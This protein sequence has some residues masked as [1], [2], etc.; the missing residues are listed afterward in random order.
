MTI[1]RAWATPLTIGA[2]ALSATTGVLMFFHVEQGLQKE[3]HEWLGWALVIGVAAHLW[4]N[5]NAFVKHLRQRTAQVLIG[6]FVGLTLVSFAPLGEEEGGGPRAGMRAVVD[7]VTHTP[8]EQIAPLAG[9]TP[10]ALID[11]LR[12][13][14]FEEATAGHTVS[15]LAE[16]DREKEQAAIA[17]LFPST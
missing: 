8:I 3:L 16:G 13:A 12:Q 6:L 5:R 10:D 1:S 14:G 2:F 4:V 9:K 7:R 11:A 17:V 15:D